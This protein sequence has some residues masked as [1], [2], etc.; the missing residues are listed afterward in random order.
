MVSTVAYR[1]IKRACIIRIE[2]GED[3]YEVIASYTKLSDDQQK[4]L[5]QE[6]MNDGLIK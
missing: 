6:L 5:I 4:Q 3:G 2:N 1:I